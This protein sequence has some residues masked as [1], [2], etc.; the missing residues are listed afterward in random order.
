[1]P[2]LLAGACPELDEGRLFGKFRSYKLI[3]LIGPIIIDF[4]GME[5]LLPL[6]LYHPCT[7]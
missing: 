3:S 2:R 1:M 7:Q 5:R 6:S 4:W